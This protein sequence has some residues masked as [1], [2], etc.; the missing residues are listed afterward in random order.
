[1][2]E[3]LPIV[4]NLLTVLGSVMGAVILLATRITRLEGRLDLLGIEMRK[5]RELAE[6]RIRQL[7]IGLQQVRDQLHHLSYAVGRHT[8]RVQQE[9]RHVEE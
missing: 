8:Q 9:T 5:D 7:E 3:W 1:M 6:H 4:L 2:S